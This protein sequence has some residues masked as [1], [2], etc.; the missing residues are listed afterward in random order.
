M[1]LILVLRFLKWKWGLSP[2]T[3]RTP[4]AS[5]GILPASHTTLFDTQ[6]CSLAALVIFSACVYG[7]V[8]KQIWVL[9]A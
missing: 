1:T 2:K 6:F 9:G 8:K 3:S 4:A 5:G 7:L